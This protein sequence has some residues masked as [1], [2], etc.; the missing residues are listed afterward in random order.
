MNNF[1]ETIKELKNISMTAEEKS[2]IRAQISM[3]VAKH[4][5]SAPIRSPWYTSKLLE[6]AVFLTLGL[7]IATSGLTFFATK[8]NPGDT[9]Y[10][11]KSMLIE[12]IPLETVSSTQIESTT[13]MEPAAKIPDTTGEQ[14]TSGGNDTMTNSTPAVAS[15]TLTGVITVTNVCE[16]T[17]KGECPLYVFENMSA[18]IRSSTGAITSVTI[19]PS[20]TF[21]TTLV[22]GSYTIILPPIGNIRTNTEKIITIKD[23]TSVSFNFTNT[24]R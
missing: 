13:F 16:A 12:P 23:N 11:F 10:P 8:A 1:N 4:P 14:T 18:S 17:H 15:H 3:F 6:G 19:N 20:G 9:L 22:N 2:R 21:E 24:V 7:V 5:V